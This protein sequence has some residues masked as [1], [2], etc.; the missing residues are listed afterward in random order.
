MTLKQKY[1]L[2]IEKME[3]VDYL[4]K[5]LGIP[6]PQNGYKCISMDSLSNLKEYAD[7]LGCEI[8]SREWDLN[9]GYPMHYEFIYK[10]I[11]FFYLAPTG[12]EIHDCK[13]EDE[14]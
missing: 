5:Q 12:E 3:G 9:E 13:R 1:D 11:C 10:K 14:L 7:G 4:S 6:S 8:V 2:V